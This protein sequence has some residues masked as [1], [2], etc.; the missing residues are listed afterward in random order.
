MNYYEKKYKRRLSLGD[1]NNSLITLVAIHLIL[2]VILFFIRAIFIAKFTDN[3]AGKEYFNDHVL[4]WFVLPAD[5]T[6]IVAKP[7]TILTHMFVHNDAFHIIGNMLWLWLFGYILV[8]LTGNRKIFPVFIYGALAGALAFVL[9]VN[10]IPSLKT[11]LPY[12]VTLEAAS[13]I[14]AV[15]AAVVTLAPGYKI[16]PMLNGGIP[17]WVIA[18]LYFLIDMFTVAKDYPATQYAHLAGALS[19]YLFIYSFRKGYDWGGWMNAVYDWFRDLFNP[20]RQLRKKNT[21]HELFYKSTGKPYKKT[22]IITERRIDE[23]LDKINQSGYHSLTEE[24][25]DVLKKASK[26]DF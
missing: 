7:W 26:E 11:D 13:G 22:P 6:Q 16:F 2:F 20:D 5:I 9:A 3:A 18:I 23:I 15:A 24:E 21:R 8:D 4:T 17:V 14:M 25:K 1:Q 19:G 10:F 12:A